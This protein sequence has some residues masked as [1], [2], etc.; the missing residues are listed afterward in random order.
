[1]PHYLHGAAIEPLSVPNDD[2]ASLVPLTRLGYH[3][4]LFLR[5]DDS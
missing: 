4:R 5:L 1:L 2:A 3:D